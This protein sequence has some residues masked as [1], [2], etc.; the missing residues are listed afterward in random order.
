MFGM[1]ILF[2][3]HDSKNECSCLNDYSFDSVPFL[4]LS[5]L[6]LYPHLHL[7][8]VPHRRPHEPQRSRRYGSDP[9]DHARQCF[10]FGAQKHGGGFDGAKDG[11]GEG[12]DGL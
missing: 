9:S 10:G 2:G 6:I 8:P 7:P 11:K 3:M 5:C 12:M 4:Q 1:V